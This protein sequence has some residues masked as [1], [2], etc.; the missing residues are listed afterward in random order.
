MSQKMAWMC[1]IDE[2]GVRQID[3]GVFRD[4]YKENYR[5]V[6][7]AVYFLAGPDSEDIAQEAFIKL[8]DA[9]PKN[10]D[11]LAAWVTRVA[12]NL[13][14]NRIRSDCAR[15]R[16]ESVTLTEDVVH[17]EEAA[18]AHMERQEVREALAKLGRRDADVLVLKYSGYSYEEIS[19][20][21]KINKSSVGT[22]IARAQAKFRSLFEGGE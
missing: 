2:S 12:V 1:Y 21:L 9:P 4:I 8:Y 17:A 16:R 6:C 5:R 13:A 7:R 3:E 10:M 22:I 11:N 19:K 18:A 20:V 14:K 15:R